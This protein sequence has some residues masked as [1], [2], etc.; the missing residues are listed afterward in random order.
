MGP[1]SNFP[2]TEIPDMLTVKSGDPL[3]N[4]WKIFDELNKSV[5]SLT[6]HEDNYGYIQLSVTASESG[7]ASDAKSASATLWV[8]VK[9]VN[10]APVGMEDTVILGEQAPGLGQ[11]VA[12]SDLS[13]MVDLRS[14]FSDVEDY[15]Y[16]E[17]SIASESGGNGMFGEDP[18]IDENDVL[19]YAIAAAGDH[20]NGSTHSVTVIARDREGAEATGT[21]EI[22]TGSSPD[23]C[24][25]QG[26][27]FLLDSTSDSGPS[28]F[29]VGFSDPIGGDDGSGAEDPEPFGEANLVM[30]PEEFED[31]P[32]RIVSRNHDQDLGNT[33][34]IVHDVGPFESLRELVNINDDE[35]DRDLE[36][37]AGTDIL[38]DNDLRSAELRV[39]IGFEGFE[40]TDQVSFEGEFWFDFPEEVK[41][42]TPIHNLYQ[43]GIWFHSNEVTDQYDD[44]DYDRLIEIKSGERYDFFAHH[45]LHNMPNPGIDIVVEGMEAVGDNIAGSFDGVITLHRDGQEDLIRGVSGSDSV[46]VTVVEID[47]D[48]PNSGSQIVGEYEANDYNEARIPVTIIANSR[49]VDADGIADF[50]DG[51]DLDDE[52]ETSDDVVDFIPENT[53]DEIPGFTEI[54]VLIPSLPIETGD[55]LVEIF[56]SDSDPANA[57]IGDS[58]P[59]NDGTGG[60]RIWTKDLTQP[61]SKLPVSAEAEDI[62]LPDEERGDYLSPGTFKLSDLKDVLGAP[63]YIEGVAPGQYLI[64]FR[65]TGMFGVSD[66]LVDKV[67]INV[68]EE[69][70]ITAVDA[71]AI[72]PVD[73]A[74]IDDGKFVISRGD[75]ATILPTGGGHAGS[76]FHWRSPI[77]PDPVFGY[78]DDIVGDDSSDSDNV[79]ADF[80]G[81][82]TYGQEMRDGDVSV[83]YKVI[84]DS[85]APFP[86]SRLTLDEGADLSESLAVDEIAWIGVANIANGESS[87]EIDVI[88]RDEYSGS[89]QVVDDNGQ[90]QQ[91]Q[92]KLTDIEW[93][94]SV[95]IELITSSEY[96]EL[97]E[98][99]KET[100]DG[101]DLPFA[102]GLELPVSEQFYTVLDKVFVGDGLAPDGSEGAMVEEDSPLYLA[103][104]TIIDSD[105]VGTQD[106][107]NLDIESTG[108]TEATT[109]NGIV[110]V[111]IRDGSVS[112][113]IE[114]GPR[115]PTYNASD[116]LV[117]ITEIDLTFPWDGTAIANTTAV[118]TFA[119]IEGVATEFALTSLSQYFAHE[120]A[121]GGPS[122]E[123]F[124]PY[125]RIRLVVVGSEELAD[126]IPTGHHDYD[127]VLTTEIITTNDD[128]EESTK[129]LKRT[130]RGSTEFINRVGDDHGWSEFGDRWTLEELSRIVPSDEITLGQNAVDGFV[131][132]KGTV[133]S[134]ASRLTTQ[135]AGSGT[136]FAVIRGDNTSANYEVDPIFTEDATQSVADDDW[137][138]L[139]GSK[140]VKSSDGEYAFTKAGLRGGAD[141]IVWTFD[142]Y[143]PGKTVQIFVS[144]EAGHDRASNAPITVSGAKPVGGGSPKTIVVDQRFVAGELAVS[145]KESN[146]WRS[147]GFFV[148]DGNG[149]INVKFDTIL[150]DGTFADGMVVAKDVVI[151]DDWG[152]E[153]A[154]QGGPINSSGGN[155]DGLPTGSRSFLVQEQFHPYDLPGS[156]NDSQFGI[157]N[158]Y[159]ARYEYNGHGLMVGYQDS[160]KNRIQYEYTDGDNDDAVDE[161]S[162][163]TDQGGLATSFAYTPTNNNITYPTGQVT[164]FTIV[165]GKV[166]KVELPNPDHVNSEAISYSF[167]YDGIYLS[168]VTDG[169]SNP[170]V[171]QSTG[172]AGTIVT[173]KN[174]NEDVNGKFM[175]VSDLG[176]ELAGN[177]HS[178]FTGAREPIYLRRSTNIID[179]SFSIFREARAEYIDGKNVTWKYQTDRWGRVIASSKPRTINEDGSV[180]LEE[181]KWTTYRNDVGLRTKFVE[182]AG[183]GGTLSHGELT[184]R[185]EY[186][187][188]FNLVEIEYADSTSES[189]T[190]HP[191]FNLTE[192]HTDQKGRV[193]LFAI[194]NFGNIDSLHESDDQRT[195]RF[196][197]R[198]P[199]PTAI[200]DLA[201]GLVR[202][203]TTAAYTDDA[204]QRKTEYV[205]EGTKVG[206]VAKTIRAYGTPIAQETQ[207]SYDNQRRLVASIDDD[208]H[209]TEHEQDLLGQY[210]ESTSVDPGVQHGAVV[211]NYQYDE[212]GNQTHAIVSEVGGG[213][214][215]VTETK[216]DELNRVKHIFLPGNNGR[217]E[218][219]YDKTGNLKYTY[220]DN[221]GPLNGYSVQQTRNFYDERGQLI[222][223]LDAENETTKFEYDQHGNVSILENAKNQKSYSEYDKLGRLEKFTDVS[224]GES[225]QTYDAVGNSKTIKN[226]RGTVTKHDYDEFDRLEKITEDYDENGTKLN[227]VT[228]F[229]YDFRNNQT[230]IKNARNY[231]TVIEYD[232]LDRIF[233]E[234]D[235]D[236]AS[237]AFVEYHYNDDGDLDWIKDKRGNKTYFEYDELHRQI[238][239]RTT[240]DNDPGTLPITTETTYDNRNNIKS[241]TDGRGIT[242][243]Y[244][245]D[246]R[247]RET[248]RYV[249]NSLLPILTTIET[250]TEYD[251]VGNVERIIDPNGNQRRFKYDGLN[252]VEDEFVIDIYGDKISH[253]T[254]EYDALGNVSLVTDIIRRVETKF[255][256]DEEMRTVT[257]DD[258][259]IVDEASTLTTTVTK[260]DANGNVIEVK[261]RRGRITK[262]KYDDLDRQT[263]QRYTQDSESQTADDVVCK[264]EYD[265][266]GNLA[267]S[268][269]PNGNA[270]KFD[271]DPS[272]RQKK[273]T[274]VRDD[275]VEIDSQ[276]FYDANGNTKWVQDFK[277]IKTHFDYDNLN[278]QIRETDFFDATI[279]SIVLDENGNIKESK[280]KNGNVTEFE[281][282]LLNRLL[283]VKYGELE[284]ITRYDNN[285]NVVETVDER[286]N[287]TN[288]KYDGLNRPIEIENPLVEGETERSKTRT[289]YLD[290]DRKREEY[291]EL[292]HK[293]VY[294]FDQH[295]WLKSV[296]AEIGTTHYL[297]DVEGNRTHLTDPGGNITQWEDIDDLG[298]AGE[299]EN[300]IGSRFY[301]YDNNG[302]VTELVDRDD[303]KTTFQYNFRDQVLFENWYAPDSDVSINSFQFQFDDNGNLDTADGQNA[304]YDFDFDQLNR[305]KSVSNYVKP[306]GVLVDSLQDF[307]LGG[308]REFLELSIGGVIDTFNDYEYD[309]LNRLESV[310]QS[311][312]ASLKMATF[313]YNEVSALEAINLYDG[314]SDTSPLV[315]STLR[316]FD[317]RNRTTQIT[318][319]GYGFDD[320]QYVMNYD[321]ANR[322]DD[323]TTPD[324]FIDYN[325]DATNQLLGAA[326]NGV[327]DDES[328]SYDDNGNRDAY[329]IDPNN[330]I[331]RDGI[332][333]YL[334]DG[335]G[336][337]VKRTEIATGDATI[338][339]YDHRNRLVKLTTKEQVDGVAETTGTVDYQYDAFGRRISKFVTPQISEEV[340]T[341]IE[342]IGI[343]IYGDDDAT[344][345]VGYIMYSALNVAERFG[346]PSP[347]AD[348]F[349]SVQHS[350]DG[351]EY[352][353]N[354]GWQS[355]TPAANDRLISETNFET[356]TVISLEGART[357]IHGIEAGYTEGDI[358][359]SPNQFDGHYNQ[360]EFSAEGTY[361]KTGGEITTTIGNNGIGIFG[362]DDAEG[363]GYILYSAQN[364]SPRFGLITQL[365]DNF[366]SVQHSS[367]GWEYH[368]NNL[369]QT[370]T[371][372]AT[373]RLLASVDFEAG[374]VTSFEGKDATIHGIAAGYATGDIE[375]VANQFAG[376]YNTGEFGA[377]GTFF[378]ISETPT[379]E[380][381]VYDGL[382]TD[383]QN[384]GDHIAIILDDAGKV[385]QRNLFGPETDQILAE[386]RVLGESTTIWT[387]GDHQGSVR[388]ILNEVPGTGGSNYELAN[389][390]IYDSFGNIVSE[391]N[392][393]FQ[394]IYSFTGRERDVESDLMYYRAR[395]Y[396]PIVGQFIS[397]DPIGF[398]AGDAD[399]RRYVG[400]GATF[401]SDASGLFDEP[402]AHMYEN[403]RPDFMKPDVAQQLIEEGFLSRGSGANAHKFTFKRFDLESGGTHY[404]EYDLHPGIGYLL[405]P[406]HLYMR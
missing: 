391:S 67:L 395:S 34:E 1:L 340:E 74:P 200:S 352:H 2:E 116:N 357:S 182:P 334:Y 374:E 307:D 61:R 70:A 248:R 251:E 106:T 100:I 179:N 303:R 167:T 366:V 249:I 177:E 287:V 197:E 272:N 377:Y 232:K 198:T 226:P 354:A 69:F 268:T 312:I 164:K 45:L 296:Q 394:S 143:E 264:S 10:D 305:L 30:G 108:L 125:R 86:T 316:D 54:R 14:Y 384:A 220:V 66:L 4:K 8:E 402:G 189:F 235:P 399:L 77:V 356:E 92:F 258:S 15:A 229:G 336:N 355:F 37:I 49:D 358:V 339:E 52:D 137:S 262:F 110:D 405:R 194:N 140:W 386:E 209:T 222:A 271:Y 25:G 400:N 31:D 126:K 245:Y 389:H 360:G 12:N 211:T 21:F 318:H 284:S 109:G 78:E 72:E 175:L 388:D 40:Q 28:E 64:E 382:R 38:N 218:Y 79:E 153:S 308:N 90:T 146:E 348:H 99:H 359:I 274:L 333:K 288:F 342:S 353:N 93:D 261:D 403:L 331:K 215:A 238:E 404:F 210:V 283:V 46:K 363:I 166:Q 234:Y 65:F 176:R 87:L 94:E 138:I 84:R 376:F 370:F 237:T 298:R 325:Y 29:N 3:S 320:I 163:V 133:T 127:V 183:G 55:E 141:S 18:A 372:V 216:Y 379:S 300:V 224:G 299:V 95:T 282:D 123:D 329:V 371:P 117:P 260:F 247:N 263:E 208:D 201:G 392:P 11:S 205:L 139:D 120:V 317:A 73:G 304:S 32:G 396:D 381:Y 145:H 302:N 383:R 255:T 9:P 136:S 58:G 270:T 53:D 50:H 244:E 75:G 119:G 212:N 151:V 39:R 273:I 168:S 365:A 297:Y 351:W 327:Q 162:K 101:E 149:T 393:E 239:S 361:F 301:K 286:G 257:E 171:I 281:Y 152:L 83:F 322:L 335:E 96:Y 57:E 250:R 114:L 362:E 380:Y 278:R 33:K 181:A 364:V 129:E 128:G 375:F 112:L 252:R 221:L 104:V 254:T 115:T 367:N 150:P 47:I 178:S 321:S 326:H 173:V 43:F 22:C 82:N 156:S 105:F 240:P 113:A 122:V 91:V 48:I 134:G 269:D 349:V 107:R 233:K 23:D 144:W 135:G 332:F 398:D 26:G 406:R 81:F 188:R 369:W 154:S 170:T 285:G 214:T 111:S 76:D 131:T 180:R 315:T 228:E 88:P 186:D 41:V 267:N 330:Q 62:E 185:F 256:H 295:G 225:T 292:D 319:S 20:W 17:F 401:K 71:F 227:L 243:F 242:T 195:T 373:D 345:G 313:G 59:Q 207:Y 147:L 236:P 130:V 323:L 63:L 89:F 196:D 19:Y 160:N 219:V 378:T 223:I 155:Y 213:E 344:T 387:L 217:I 124:N 148:P 385:I 60:L 350:S 187:D 259:K 16:L 204:V 174:P 291:D 293:T 289:V 306:L 341:N 102:R 172:D 132:D 190:F 231:A 246:L 265:E 157:H 5:L 103:T 290:S 42:W 346:L 36:Y 294:Q 169:R 277:G 159:G 241:V 279:E 338:Y 27:G 184:T 275:G 328:Y 6:P 7:N 347:L 80:I 199:A 161:L 314:L 311:G 56:Y 68:V 253:V 192:T 44:T 368:N 390:L 202:L 266:V 397:E 158:K 142:G 51:F 24:G 343:G 165:D 118:L 230:L 97:F 121:S 85:E 276:I 193:A 35:K 98:L 191:T 337:R 280:D 206:L 309:D 324:G 203:Q 13:R 310:Q